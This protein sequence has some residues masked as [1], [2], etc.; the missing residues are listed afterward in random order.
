MVHIEDLGSHFDAPIETVWKFINSPADHGE[1][2]SDRRNVR[3]EPDGENRMKSSWEQNVQGHW[4]KVQNQVTMFPPVAML[5]HSVE[6][7]LAGSKFIF[8]YSPKGDKTGVNVIGDFR[9]A[10]IPPAQLEQAVMASL[11]AAFNDDQAAIRRM[12]GKK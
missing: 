2:H 4:V 5:I 1:S 7:P 12:A 3:G 8:Y 6:G 11:E 9:S 10:S